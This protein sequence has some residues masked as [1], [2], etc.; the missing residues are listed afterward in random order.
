M[1]QGDGQ[2]L[3]VRLQ[4]N[5]RFFKS[6]NFS[7]TEPWLGGSRPN[8]FTIGAVHSTYDYT[9]LASGSLKI[10]RGFVGLGAQLKWPD[11]FFGSSTTLGIENIKLNNYNRSGFYVPNSKGSFNTL[12]N[13]NFKN[14]S[15]SQVFYRS[16]VADPIYPRSGSKISLSLKFT[17]PYSLFRS[18]NYWDISSEAEQELIDIENKKRGPRN[19]L[20]QDEEQ[21][22]IF[23][24][25][26]AKKF[27]YLEYHKWNFNAEWYFNIYE[28]LVIAT[29]AKIGVLG[30]YN[31]NI[32][33]SPFER[34]ELGGDGLSNQTI[35]IT[36]KDIISLR[37]Y[38]VTD[39]S[40]NSTG[41]A[42]I[43]E[44][45][46]VEL[47]YPLSLNPSSSIY[48]M[49]FLQAGNSWQEFSKFSPFE[50]KRSAG[51]GLRVFLPMFGLLGFDYGFG[52][53]KNLGT[54]ASY[55]DYSKFSVI[56]GFEP[57]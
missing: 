2:K 37:G 51:V 34:F 39:I 55:K 18:D 15:L 40:N 7:F 46:T 17:L 27:E 44:K 10:T 38:D 48:V 20:T 12:D 32:G 54:D 57:E 53:D 22:L 47:R 52:F 42:S 1:P 13:G 41:G 45:F 36:G 29:K 33:L 30:F 8:S 31:D 21:S 5:S 28:K 23:K 4:S 43:F 35:G 6:Y 16:S 50:L 11:D 56:L 3:S 26:S 19:P 9:E 49:T 25:E 14:I 24:H